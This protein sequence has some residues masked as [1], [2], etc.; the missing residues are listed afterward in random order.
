MPISAVQ[1]VEFTK[2]VATFTDTSTA[3]VA[4]DFLASIAWGDGTTTAG[5]ITE[6]ANDTFYVTGTHTYTKAG[7]F[8]PVVTIKDP[9]GTLYATGSFNQTNLVSSVSGMAGVIDPSLIN[10]WGMSSSATSPIWVSDQGT[11]VS[12]LYNPNG[13]PIKQ[14]LTVTIPAT[15]I[16]SGPTGQV[17]NTDTSMRVTSPYSGVH[18]RGS[19]HLFLFASTSTAPP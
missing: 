4:S 6:D 12:T 7:P 18:D 17:F 19:V 14:P 8:T 16:P 10:P 3:A 13:N 5:A 15:G 9:S 1:D 2:A 11:G